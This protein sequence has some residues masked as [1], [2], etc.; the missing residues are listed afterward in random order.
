MEAILQW[1]GKWG[2][3][4][5]KSD[6]Y[7]EMCKQA[8]ELT[9]HEAEVGDWYADDCHGLHILGFDDFLLSSEKTH[10]EI[11]DDNYIWLPR[12][13]QLIYMISNSFMKSHIELE[14][15]FLNH[16]PH[17]NYGSGEQVWLCLVMHHLYK[18]SWNGSNWIKEIKDLI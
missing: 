16:N 2:N 12:I 14:H 15:W 17:I 9:T 18:K 5:D 6:E 13:D 10:A 11:C 7:I 3:N 4:M 8:K 1:G